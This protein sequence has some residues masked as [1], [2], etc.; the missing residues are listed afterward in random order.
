MSTCA[1]WRICPRLSPACAALS[2]S[3]VW[4][5][6]EFRGQQCARLALREA[7]RRRG[8]GSGAHFDPGWFVDRAC[9]VAALL[10]MT[11][12]NRFPE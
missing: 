8:L 11:T 6:D 9:F 10:A 1:M 2:V 7:K 5:A 3:R 12:D 4:S